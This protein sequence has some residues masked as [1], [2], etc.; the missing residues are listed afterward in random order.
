MRILFCFL[1]LLKGLYLFSEEPDALFLTWVDQPSQSIVIQWHSAK[2]DLQEVYYQKRGD[3]EWIFAEGES[4]KLPKVNIFLY[5]LRIKDLS[6]DSHY[7]FKF[8]KKEQVYAFQT[9]PKQL[10][11]RPIKFVIAGDAYQDPK[12][13]RSM[14]EQIVKKDPDFIVIGGDIAY[15]E[16]PFRNRSAKIQ[17]WESFFKLCKKQLMT[18]EGRIIP[19]L[20]VVGNHDVA[21]GDNPQT[22]SVLFYEYF[23]FPVPYLPYRTLKIG[24]YAAIIMLDSGHSYPVYG[25]QTRWLEKT[26]QVHAAVPYRFAVYHVPAYPSVHSDQRLRSR[27]IRENWVPL[28]EEHYLTAFEHHNH[29]Y[30]RTYPIR[31]GKVDPTGIIYLGDG[32]WGVPPRVVHKAWYLA[33]AER[34]NNFWLL[35]LTEEKCHFQSFNIHGELIEEF[36]LSKE[37]FEANGM[38]QAS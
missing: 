19:I 30:K 1:F 25:E 15:A 28:F 22:E 31:E 9:L 10:A 38:A 7:L 5:S 13:F 3:K 35:T 14:N 24:N 20:P 29:A 37:V 8:E 2:S 23:T 16:R 32:A 26:L 27:E 33:K 17:R 12:L 11:Q 18:K 4:K 6:E 21:A 34:L 36:S